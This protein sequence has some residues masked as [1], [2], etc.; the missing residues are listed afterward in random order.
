M[1]WLAVT[2]SSSRAAL[3]QKWLWDRFMEV[4]QEGA[5]LAAGLAAASPRQH[6]PINFFFFFLTQRSDY[7]P[8]FTSAKTVA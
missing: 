7:T 8:K 3:V 4:G 2:W 6:P 1:L 5:Q